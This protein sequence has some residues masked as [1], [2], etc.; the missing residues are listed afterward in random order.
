MNNLKY[1]LSVLIV[2]ICFLTCSTLSAQTLPSNINVDQ[3]SED[4]I[5]NIMQRGQAQGLND[6]QI[7]QSAIDRG[8]PSTQ[9]QR[10]QVRMADIRKRAGNGVSDTTK[11]VSRQLNYKDTT[12]NRKNEQVDI[13]DDFKPK[14]F[15]ADLFRNSVSNPFE[16]NLKIATPVNYIVG[17]DDKL[18][19]NVSGK[20]VM[21]WNTTVSPDGNI[22]ISGV[23]ILKVAG[24]TIEQVRIDIK[25]K[26]LANNYAI[27]RGTSLRV[28]LGDIRSIHV[29]MQGQ[30][31][32][33]G[34]YTV[35]SLATVM[36][37]LFLA[38][39]PND[40]G[41][42]RKVQVIRN[43]RVIRNLDIY[44]FLVK[45]SQEGNITLR[46]QDIIRVP[47]YGIR[48]ELIGEVKIPALFE[49]LPGETVQ[50]L[51]NFSGGFTDQAYT[52]RIKVDRVIDQ[53]HSLTD[54]VETDYK[55]TTPLRGDKYII[56]K[57]LNRYQNRV[58]IKGAVFRP[59]DFELQRGLT[60]S[61]LIKN[62]GGLREDA[63]TTRGSI[64][65]LNSDNTTAQMSFNINDILSK[66]GSDIL[67]QRE[68]QVTIS[69]I[70]DLREAYT[71]TINGQVRRPGVF[72]YA[73]SITVADLIIKAGGFMEGATGNRIQVSRRIYDSNPNSINTSISNVIT[74]DVDPT[75]NDN[76]FTLKPFDIV[77]VYSTPGYAVQKT[78]TLEGEIIYPGPYTIKLKNEKISDIIA[79]AG[80]LTAAAD[81]EGSSLKRENAAILGVD[82]TKVD[83]AELNKQR[84]EQLKQL[85]NTYKEDGKEPD[86]IF[87]NNFI[88][89]DL[90]NILRK[91]GSA[92]DLI[93]EDGDVLRIPKQQQIVKVNGEVLYPSAVV[94][95]KGKSFKEYILNAGGFSPKALKR[96]AM[97]VYPN[98]TVK[99]TRKFLFF[100]IRPR[101]KP[102]SEIYVAKKP[103]TVANTAQTIL[104]FTTGLASLGAIILGILSLNNK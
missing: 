78:V 53:Q 30:V 3:Y 48:V 10:L 8:M 99:G 96:G 92:I 82:K 21:S 51:L 45:D 1:H 75:L 72:A 76:R 101:V 55:T 15:G 77:S 97:I 20:S 103:T 80:G 44:D 37:A 66:P 83:T 16:S 79:R 104:G 93:L 2:L 12:Q 73:D 62:A 25:N 68:D 91:P 56:E 35:S 11:Q 88:G 6:E 14:I 28:D 29:I 39:G 40:I 49:V 102:G 98:G 42:F 34:T 24:K 26:L 31:V 4:Q 94:Y 95:Q 86:S 46:D 17:P 59:G 9:A 63:F 58:T 100:N 13:F 60:L 47:T 5:K 36:N 70:F 50:D 57:I 32:K 33:P 85:Q 22:N 89:I 67:L 38:G 41:S 61:Q 87:R 69:S 65:R 7:V 90:K 71:V 43:S 27:D 84:R 64:L 54:I 81:I 19:I 74:I 52:A 23:G 18:L